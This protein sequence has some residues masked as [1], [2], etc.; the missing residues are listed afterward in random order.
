[1]VSGHPW[2]SAPLHY[3][4]VALRSREGTGTCGLRAEGSNWKDALAQAALATGLRGWQEASGHQVV[5]RTSDIWLGPSTRRCFTCGQGSSMPTLVWVTS[6]R[7]S[8]PTGSKMTLL[9]ISVY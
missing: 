3:T 9:N 2:P 1:M 4:G 5:R 7:T 8:R 6:P